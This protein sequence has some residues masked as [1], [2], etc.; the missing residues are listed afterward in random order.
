MLAMLGAGR[1][2]G[3]VAARLLP[4][5]LVVDLFDPRPAIAPT[6]SAVPAASAPHGGAKRAE[7]E[8]QEE[9]REQ[10]SEET[11]AETPVRVAVIRDRRG[12]GGDRGGEAL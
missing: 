12:A 11:E 3:L 7:D 1:M 4:V 6:S 10:E 8:E 9:E 5:Q 2:A